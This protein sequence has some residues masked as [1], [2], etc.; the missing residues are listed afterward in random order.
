VDF[1]KAKD[2]TKALAVPLKPMR[3]HKIDF[4]LSVK[5]NSKRLLIKRVPTINVVS[6]NVGTQVGF[7][8][9]L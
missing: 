6:S 5:E 8:S 2:A 4:C 1:G 9:I 3:L 7:H